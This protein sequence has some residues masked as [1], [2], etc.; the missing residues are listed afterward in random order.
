MSSQETAALRT[1]GGHKDGWDKRVGLARG[2]MIAL[3]ATT[4]VVTTTLAIIARSELA[5][6]GSLCIPC[7]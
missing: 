1:V 7:W 6:T 4:A 5:H 2:A 3:I